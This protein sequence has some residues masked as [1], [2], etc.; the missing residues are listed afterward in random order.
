MCCGYT[1]LAA[2]SAAKVSSTTKCHFPL[3]PGLHSWPNPRMSMQLKLVGMSRLNSGSHMY[4]PMLHSSVL[5]A[6]PER[7]FGCAAM[8]YLKSCF[9]AGCLLCS[10]L[11]VSVGFFS[12]C[13]LMIQQWPTK[14]SKACCL[15]PPM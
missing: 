11:C 13:W 12:K 1:P 2:T 14:S 7:S 15:L 8:L 10:D 9:R 4:P 3:I 5:R 6:G